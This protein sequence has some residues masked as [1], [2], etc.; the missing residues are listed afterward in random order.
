[1]EEVNTGGLKKFSWKNDDLKIEP[2]REEA[3]KEGYEKYEIRRRMERRN[4][5]IFVIVTILIVLG[6]LGYFLLR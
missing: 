3:I 2:E 1:M 4:L 6:F 5:I